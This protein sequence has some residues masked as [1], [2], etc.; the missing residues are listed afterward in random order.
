M[1]VA[2]FALV[3]LLFRVEALKSIKGDG[4]SLFGTVAFGGSQ[5]KKSR[6]E[7][8][9]LQPGFVPKVVAAHPDQPE[10]YRALT[11][12][13]GWAYNT[14]YEGSSCESDPY[15]VF[16]TAINL[17]YQI[18]V[19]QSLILTCDSGKVHSLALHVL[20]HVL[21]PVN[22]TLFVAN[23]VA[24]FYDSPNCDPATFSDS[25]THAVDVCLAN[26]DDYYVLSQASV[27]SCSNDPNYSLPPGNWVV[28]S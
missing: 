14:H 23:V 13:L 16:G 28:S 9:G 2:F 17:C 21:H 25:N 4:T 7:S 24:Y 6:L 10:K 15:T 8:T 19:S 27:Y 5:L 20:L 26:D 18:D 12:T 1:L 22:D 11:Q 3:N